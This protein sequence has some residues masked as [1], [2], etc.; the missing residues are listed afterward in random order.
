MTVKT[1]LTGELE[2]LSLRILLQKALSR[3]LSIALPEPLGAEERVAL[4]QLQVTDEFQYQYVSAIA[5]QLAATQGTTAA[6]LAPQLAAGMTAYFAPPIGP[7]GGAAIA[8]GLQVQPTPTG[9]LILTLSAAGLAAWLQNWQASPLLTLDP[10]AGSVTP[11]APLAGHWPLCERLQLSLPMLLQWAY[12]RCQTWQQALGEGRGDERRSRLPAG[13]LSDLPEITRVLLPTSIQGLD[14]IAARGG[15]PQVWVR[16]GYG[17][18]A[19]VYRCEAARGQ[20]P[21]PT[22]E[23]EA[24][25]WSAATLAATQKNLAMILS[26]VWQLSPC[27][28]L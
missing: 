20:W 25:V 8:S 1:P 15:A 18:A 13:P 7:A 21:A 9:W 4:S 23:A 24:L 28:Q 3:Y 12:A 6:N 16:Q 17:L 11:L 10:A 27:R 26:H 5:H 19:Q 22:D 14:Q 2:Q